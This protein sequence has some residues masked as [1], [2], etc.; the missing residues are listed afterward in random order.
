M[1][2]RDCCVALPRCAIG[3]S[4]VCDCGISLSYSL[5]ILVAFVIVQGFRTSIAKKPFS[6][7][8]FN[9]GPDTLPTPSGSVH[10]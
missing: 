5:T 6:F 4:T 7:V 8:V 9:G 1:V 10:V 3:L 2:S